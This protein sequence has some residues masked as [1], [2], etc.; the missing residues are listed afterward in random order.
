MTRSACWIAL[1]G[2]GVLGCQT[3]PERLTVQPLA[4]D[5]QPAPFFDLLNRA[6][7]QALAAT[8]ASYVDNWGGVE[9]GARSLRE[10][11]RLLQAAQDVPPGRKAAVDSLAASLTGL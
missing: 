7:G 3:P 4:E 11:A 1:L 10:T 2:L 8:E 5:G 6:R 9:D